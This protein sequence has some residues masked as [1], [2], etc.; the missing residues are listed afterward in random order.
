MAEEH[1]IH[2]WVYR[3]EI[4]IEVEKNSRGTNV[5]LKAKASSVEEAMALLRDARAKVQAEFEVQQ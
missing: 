2:E 5:T 4:S 1:V 3:P